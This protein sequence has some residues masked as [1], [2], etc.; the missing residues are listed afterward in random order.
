MYVQDMYS[1]GRQWVKQC[2]EKKLSID[3]II[4]MVNVYY[5][6]PGNDEGHSNIDV[7]PITTNN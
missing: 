6:E 5:N 4:Q 1:T 3:S 2:K 7:T